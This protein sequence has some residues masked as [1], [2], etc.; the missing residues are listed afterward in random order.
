MTVSRHQ[1]DDAAFWDRAICLDC[2]AVRDEA[3]DEDRAWLCD[4]CNA[5]SVYSARFIQ[6]ALM[7]VDEEEEG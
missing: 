6:E 1:V 5:P 2:G 3:E 4:R 7:K